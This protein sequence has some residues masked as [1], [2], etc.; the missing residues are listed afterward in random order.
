MQQE[1][2]GLG[3]TGIIEWPSDNVIYMPKGKYIAISKKIEDPN[4]KG[5][6]R[7]FGHSIK[8]EEEGFIFRTS[9]SVTSQND[10]MLEI[11]KLRMNHHNLELKAK[12]MQ[13]T[14][15]AF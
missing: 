14:W 2:K 6:I 1:Q 9:S 12:S 11:D 5:Q 15:I 4:K 7:Q 3:L 8:S 13:K 10:L